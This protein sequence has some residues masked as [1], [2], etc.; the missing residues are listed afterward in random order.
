MFDLSLMCPGP[1]CCKN[2]TC[3]PNLEQTK[4]YM[5]YTSDVDPHRSNADPDPQNLINAD[6]DPGQ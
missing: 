5:V 1:A 4:C 6:P 3:I 2:A